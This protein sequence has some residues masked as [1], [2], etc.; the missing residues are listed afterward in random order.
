MLWELKHL[1]TTAES[2]QVTLLKHIN[3]SSPRWKKIN[4]SIMVVMMRSFDQEWIPE[5]IVT[6]TQYVQSDYRK[7]RKG[8]QCGGVNYPAPGCPPAWRVHLALCRRGVSAGD[9]VCLPAF[10]SFV[11]C[12]A[13][14]RDGGGIGA[15][16]KH[17]WH[18][19]NWPALQ[20][21]MLCWS[22]NC[23]ATHRK[24]RG[25]G[26]SSTSAETDCSYRHLFS[27]ST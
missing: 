10:A 27:S 25:Y 2:M 20:H 15:A 4:G 19:H 5:L 11:G 22:L 14:T 3:H 8:A 9:V 16:S 6:I 7:Q 18:F 26:M 23:C 24:Y 21:D 12:L 13:R 1:Q 17:Q